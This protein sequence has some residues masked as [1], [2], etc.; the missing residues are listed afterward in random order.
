L[1]RWLDTIRATLAPNTVRRHGE[2]TRIHIKPTIGKAKLS[3]LDPLQ[4]QSLYRSKLDEG[5]SAATVVKIHSTLSKSLK[6]AVRWRLTV[7]SGGVFGP[8]WWL[9]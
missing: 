7:A 4:V 5:L 2:L 6:Q 9:R 8:S 3:K 1:D